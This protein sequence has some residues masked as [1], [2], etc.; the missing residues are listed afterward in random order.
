MDTD[1]FIDNFISLA[2]TKKLQKFFEKEKQKGCSGFIFDHPVDIRPPFEVFRPEDF[3]KNISNA[4][5]N[6]ERPYATRK[7]NIKTI[8]LW[9]HKNDNYKAERIDRFIRQLSGIDSPVFFEI[10]GNCRFISICLSTP[11]K[12][13][14][15]LKSLVLTT[16]PMAEIEDIEFNDI[17][18]L[19]CLSESRLLF[20]DFCPEPPYYRQLTQF[21]HI[22][23]NSPLEAIFSVINSLDECEMGVYRVAVHPFPQNENWHRN[24]EKLAFCEQ[25]VNQNNYLQLYSNQSDNDFNAFGK[26]NKI[27][28]GK[29]SPDLPFLA[30]RVSFAAFVKSE[31]KSGISKGVDIFV[32]NYRYGGNALKIISDDDFIQVIGSEEA[33]VDAV[34]N[35]QSFTQGMILNSLENRRLRKHPGFGVLEGRV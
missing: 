16:F 15:T 22:Q 13:R 35:H 29:A 5:E 27:A 33:L 24:I 25:Q 17:I 8:R 34:M 21:P 2:L 7:E 10:V 6:R 19:K 23:E 26:T 18:P 30:V 20:R 28:E 31:S 14:E 1:I 4:D 32:G 9:L 11:V 12:N 3:D